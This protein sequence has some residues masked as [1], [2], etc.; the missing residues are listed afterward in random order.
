MLTLPKAELSCW[1][2]TLP[3]RAGVFLGAASTGSFHGAPTSL[4]TKGLPWRENRSGNVLQQSACGAKLS[5]GQVFRGIA[6]LQLNLKVQG[7]GSTPK[8]VPAVR[9]AH[10]AQLL[11]ILFRY[12]GSTTTSRSLLACP[13]LTK[14]SNVCRSSRG[15]CVWG[16]AQHLVST[17]RPLQ[18]LLHLCSQWQSRLQGFR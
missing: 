11:K 4:C 6:V 16:R 8:S 9:G 14:R 13:P 3:F 10:T 12:G 7:W 2:R 17:T 5:H 18:N 15:Q 1:D